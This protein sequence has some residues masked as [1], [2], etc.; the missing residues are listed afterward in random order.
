MTEIDNATVL[1]AAELFKQWMFTDGGNT[2]TLLPATKFVEGMENRYGLKN[3]ENNQFVKWEDGRL[4]IDL[5]YTSAEVQRW[6]V[7]R[8]VDSTEPIKYGETIAIGL[9]IDPTWVNFEEQTFGVNLG[10]Q[11]KAS[12]EWRILGGPIGTPVQTN[13]R[14]ALFNEKSMA[15]ESVRGEPLIFFDRPPRHFDAGWPTSQGL[16]GNL[17]DLFKNLGEAIIVLVKVLDLYESVTESDEEPKPG[18]APR[19]TTGGVGTLGGGT[20][21]RK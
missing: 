7:G 12:C 18:E 6:I 2:R 19:V 21:D 9:G 1:K 15:S 10:Y 11:S 3:L 5:G 4:G 17:G 20:I 13:E 14:V 8:C 16:L